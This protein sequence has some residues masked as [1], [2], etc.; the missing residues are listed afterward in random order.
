MFFKVNMCGSGPF[1]VFG[2]S[3]RF[4][5]PPFSRSV[6]SNP[7]DP[8]RVGIPHGSAA[9]I[10]LF[11]QPLETFWK[12]ARSYR[13]ELGLRDRNGE[14]MGTPIWQH[15]QAVGTPSSLRTGEEAQEI[16]V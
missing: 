13:L 8:I 12:I 2:V 3:E 11:T 1:R 6:W 9:P 7:R 14:H 16:L 15:G 10:H 5:V 4:G